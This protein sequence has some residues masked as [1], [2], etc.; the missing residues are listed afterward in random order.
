MQESLLHAT[1]TSRDK[2]GC[3]DWQTTPQELNEVLGGTGKR[4]IFISY[5]RKALPDEALAEH[6][7]RALSKY[8]DVFIDKTM[9]VGTSW[10][11]CIEN[12]IREA[13][14]LISLL[15]A[16]SIN[17]EMIKGEIEKAHQFGK[18]QEGR[19]AILP[20]RLAYHDPLPYALSPYLNPLN[21]SEWEGDDDTPRLIEELLLAI[22]GGTLSSAMPPHGAMQDEAEQPRIP[23]P[24]PAAPLE[25][26][27]GTIAT[28][29]KFYVERKTDKVAMTA[30]QRQGVTIPIKGP[31]QMGK[32]SLLL[33]L[34]E[35]AEGL[36]KRA[37]VLDF[38]LFDEKSLASDEIFFRQFCVWLTAELGEENKV[39]DFWDKD[40]GNPQ[41]TTRYIALHLLKKVQGQLV[42][43]M[44]EV[45]SVLETNFRSDF[46][47]MLRSWHN[48]RARPRLP[49]KRLDLV[50][51]TSTE[52]YQLIDNL[53]QSPFNVGEIINLEDFNHE[54]VADLNR[55]H[56]MALLQEEERRLMRLVRGHPYLVRRA[57]YLVAS[58]Q[59]SAASLFEHAAD[60]HGPFGDHLRYHLFRMHDKADLVAAMINVI[61]R[62]GCDDENII[63]R[64]RGAGLIRREGDAVVPRCELY[65]QYFG[66]H[67]HAKQ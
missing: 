4:R 27:E 32:S 29:S 23:Q 18:E 53:N 38:Q 59:L 64:L 11:E 26:P 34:V 6:L 55:R 57:L 62:R 8:H 60:E 12:K 43:A 30:I 14:F 17:S 22:S 15:S 67:L 63:H 54:Q 16:R 44:D 37:V 45:E 51:V 49:W 36:G 21:W 40:L 47:G 41:R 39:D 13:D 61:N 52:P 31:R 28:E 9:L 25:S 42:L 2:M 46:F 5:K 19:P 66:R 65:A 10:A 3:P 33:R 24:L 50:I 7:F 35:A 1:P 56:G 20:V 48:D 58:G